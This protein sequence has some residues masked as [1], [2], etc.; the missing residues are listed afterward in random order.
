MQTDNPDEAAA[1]ER[2]VIALQ[3]RLMES[4]RSVIETH[5]H[6][7]HLV[8]AGAALSDAACD[9]VRLRAAIGAAN[10][11]HAALVALLA[12]LGV[13]RL[14]DYQRARLD[15]LRLEVEAYEDVLRKRTGQAP[16]V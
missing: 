16:P 13:I 15:M 14:A 2:D 5:K 12:A 6:A 11:D 10:A 7:K 1:L 3:M 8:P 9:P 4:V